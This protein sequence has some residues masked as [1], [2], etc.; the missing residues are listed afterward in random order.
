MSG[1][2][3]EPEER[4]RIYAMLEADEHSD[5]GVRRRIWIAGALVALIVILFVADRYVTLVQPNIERM[6]DRRDLQSVRSLEGDVRNVLDSY[7]I[8]PEWIREKTVDME[9]I[10]HVRDLW[11]VQVPRNLPVA[12]VNLDLKSVVAD[13]GARAFAV[14]NARLGEI[15]LHITFRGK[16]RYSLLFT[17]SGNVK[18]AAGRIVLL[19]DGLAEAPESEIEKYIAHSGH[20]ACIIDPN[21]DAVPLH[22]RL[23]T[24]G[25][26]VV[27]HLHFRPGSDGDSRY[28][29]AE[30]LQDEELSIHLRYI[31]KN[32]P[33]SRFYYVT[34]ER[35][36]GSSMRRVDAIMQ[37][38]GYRALESSLFSYLDRS[39]QES[40][41]TARMND[42]AA[43][44]VREPIAIGVV[45]LRDGVMNFLSKEMSH[46]RKK[47][48]DFVPLS[49]V[50]GEQ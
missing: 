30:D 16:I 36:L 18:R 28:E 33:G 38:L 17:P 13:Y 9:G 34:S 20:I 14:E 7:G 19:V 10:G 35:A 44:A 32:L 31:V 26:E 50:L 37:S 23:R 40:V 46:L 43:S 8:I 11:V 1:P 22:T 15:S 39:A 47:G 4:E 6:Q 5:R 45:E 12:S 24:A 41:M 48:H 49:T 29:L 42:L 25:K 3:F 2:H 21:K 27:L